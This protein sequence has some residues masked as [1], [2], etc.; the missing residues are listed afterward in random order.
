MLSTADI[1]R[2]TPIFKDMSVATERLLCALCPSDFLAGDTI[3]G[4]DDFR[5][6]RGLGVLL[7]GKASIYGGD[8]EKRILMNRLGV[9]DVFGAA[10][11][12]FSEE[13]SVTT[14]FA[15]TKA[16][17]LFIER[18]V[19]ENVIE[20]DFAVASAYIAFLSERIHFLNRK[21]LG[22]TAKNADAALAGYLL[23]NADENGCLAANMSRIAST[24]G[25]GRTTLYR[26]ADALQ[27][28]GAMV[29]DGKKMQILDRTFLENKSK[30]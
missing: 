10:T 14:V 19:L 26:A 3:A 16:S 4:A 11:V 6:L 7:C 20:T 17:V 30:E 15:Q 1:L 2:R 18:S 28:H 13:E 23:H 25:I 29:Y 24:L 8:G 9:G 5:A 22:F 27:A 21:I 12:F